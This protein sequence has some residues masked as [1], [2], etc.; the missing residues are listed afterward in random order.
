M[1]VRPAISAKRKLSPDAHIEE[2]P[3][4]L[5]RGYMPALY[6]D[7]ANLVLRLTI[8]LSACSRLGKFKVLPARYTGVGNTW[9]FETKEIDKEP[10]PSKGGV[11]CNSWKFSYAFKEMFVIPASGFLD[12]IQASEHEVTFQ[13]NLVQGHTHAS[14]DEDI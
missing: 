3:W 14:D 13:W 5:L 7:D 1:V 8:P 12:P 11:N 9:I 10:S 2:A 6:F 4:K